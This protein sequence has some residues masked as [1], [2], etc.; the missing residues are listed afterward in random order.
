MTPEALVLDLA[1]TLDRVGLAYML[2]GSLASSLHGMP[3]STRD[4]DLV[5]DPDRHQL[6]SLFAKLPAESYYADL[7]GALDALARRGQF[8]VVDYASGWKIDF[9]IRKERPFSRAEFERRTSVDFGGSR[10][11]VASAEDVLLAKLEW[12]KLSGG[13]ER[14]LEDAAGILSGQGQD[15]DVAYIE[16]WADELDLR[17]PLSEARKLATG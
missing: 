2:T 16:K 11:V 5:I 7:T 3:R 4:I 10:L 12:S 17:G 8:N 1:A 15:L 6:E 13:S 14:Q 9:I